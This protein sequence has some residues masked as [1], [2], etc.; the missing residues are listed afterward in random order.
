MDEI[1]VRAIKYW[2]KI[3]NSRH[4]F[5]TVHEEQIHHT[6]LF[7]ESITENIHREL[8]TV[9]RTYPTGRII[10]AMLDQSIRLPGTANG[11]NITVSP[12]QNSTT[13]QSGSVFCVLS[14]ESDARLS[15][16]AFIETKTDIGSFNLLYV[17]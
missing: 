13:T 14:L 5:E 6:I 16:V 1:D 9:Y 11:W 2:T 3:K 4:I 12:I 15:N 10:R 8:C 17:T 7:S